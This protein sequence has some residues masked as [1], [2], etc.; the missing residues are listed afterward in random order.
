MYARCWNFHEKKKFTDSL[1][2]MD[3]L[4]GKSE[5]GGQTLYYKKYA[6]ANEWTPWAY[7]SE[8]HINIDFKSGYLSQGEYE[9][10]LTTLNG[11]NKKEHYQPPDYDT[12][13]DSP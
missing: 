7:I 8:R 10:A 11:K 5:V 3:Y 4:V 13:G 1:E 6:T 9:E 12:D 2:F